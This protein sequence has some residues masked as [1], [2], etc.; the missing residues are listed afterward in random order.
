M[1]LVLKKKRKKEK[2]FRVPEG[3]KIIKIDSEFFRRSQFVLEV[4]TT[5]PPS[6]ILGGPP[7]PQECSV[8]AE[9]HFCTRLACTL[10]Y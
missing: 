6:R 5:V 10:P 7:R 3:R 8:R 4:N 2:N 9:T 1:S